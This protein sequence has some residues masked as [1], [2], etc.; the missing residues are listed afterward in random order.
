MRWPRWLVSLFPRLAPRGVWADAVRVTDYAALARFNR[1]YAHTVAWCRE[2]AIF[3]Q[4]P[5]CLVRFRYWPKDLR[6]PRDFDNLIGRVLSPGVIA[7]DTHGTLLVREA[8]IDNERLLIH[9]AKHAITGES[10]HPDW[11]FGRGA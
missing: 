10:G 5:D 9:E 2:R 4:S 1:C 7:G 6:A 3:V 11:L 8:M